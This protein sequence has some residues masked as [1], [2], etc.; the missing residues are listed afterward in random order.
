M[1]RHV[2]NDLGIELAL[3]HDEV[4]Q[5]MTNRGEPMTRRAVQWAEQSALKKLSQHPALVELASELDWIE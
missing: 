4:A 1:Q 3:S 5:I 2:I